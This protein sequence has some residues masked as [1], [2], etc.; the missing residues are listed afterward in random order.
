M[1]LGIHR[2]LLVAGGVGATF[3]VP[4][5]R[6]L[7]QQNPG[8]K[9]RLAWAV[10]AAGDVSWAMARGFG[11]SILDNDNVDIF[12]TRNMGDRGGVGDGPRDMEL[13]DLGANG[14]GRRFTL[15]DDR[16]RPNLQ[17]LVDDLFDHGRDEHVAVL[18]CGPPE[19]ARE[20]RKYVTPW[21][22]KDRRVFWHSEG[23]GW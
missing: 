23:F 19:M 9:V 14:T 20:L 6:A 18:V 7:V 22:M 8:I 3:A 4:I 2:I 11:E 5:Y 13:R 10:R 1:G 17:R 21:V 12:V 15:H 16:K